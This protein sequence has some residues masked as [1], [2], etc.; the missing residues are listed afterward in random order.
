M[1][2]RIESGADAANTGAAKEL[3]TAATAKRHATRA[4]LVT[5]GSNA[6]TAGRS[7][8][9]DLETTYVL[10]RLAAEARISSSPCPVAILAK[11]V[12]QAW[13]GAAHV[14]IE[15]PS[16][17]QRSTLSGVPITASMLARTACCTGCSR[18][19]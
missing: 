5:S 2:V 9:A 12:A 6:D 15:Q 10:D 18:P 8:L 14:G 16:T 3:N 1:C 17:P 4:R 11:P 19:T 7:H 13:M